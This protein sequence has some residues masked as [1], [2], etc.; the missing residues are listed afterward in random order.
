M[1][2]V[3]VAAVAVL[4]L[5]SSAA[6]ACG[7]VGPS[8]CVTPGGKCEIRGYGYG[9]EGGDRP[10]TL[11]W[12]SDG[13]I[14]AVAQIDGNGDFHAVITAPDNVGLYKLVVYQGNDDPDPVDVSIPVVA[15]WYLR[16]IDAL[17][18]AVPLQR[19]TTVGLS[20]IGVGILLLAL[21]LVLRRRAQPR[22][23]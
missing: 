5:A 7:Q 8:E 19:S 16:P 10:V 18:S 15:P 3:L 12:V 22:A 11:K 20:L 23:A 1:R 2:R 21:I 17:Q 9:F 13:S 14:A 4:A 6:F